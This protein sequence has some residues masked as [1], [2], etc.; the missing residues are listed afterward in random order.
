MRFYKAIID[1]DTYDTWESELIPD[2]KVAEKEF[3]RSEVLHA[4]PEELA[5]A[6]RN[7]P[8][9]DP[10]L[11]EALCDEAG[12]SDEWRDADGDGFEAVAFKAADAL[13]V[14]IL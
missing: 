13:G 1:T 7:A 6:I 11:L 12:L 8:A 5:E 3:P 9:W 2:W 14:E 4:T 10:E